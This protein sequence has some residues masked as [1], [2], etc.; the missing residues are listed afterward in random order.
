MEPPPALRATIQM[1]HLGCS[2]V[3][4]RRE[5]D[6]LRHI[7]LELLEMRKKLEVLQGR[8]QMCE[9][10]CLFKFHREVRYEIQ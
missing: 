5:R 7:A 4:T 9:L 3:M 2:N 10:D 8:K 6:S 1:I